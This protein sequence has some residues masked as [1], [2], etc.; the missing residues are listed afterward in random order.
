MTNT[1]IITITNKNT[2]LYKKIIQYHL[3]VDDWL[4]DQEDDEEPDADC[5]LPR[6]DG[7]DEDEDGVYVELVRM[8]L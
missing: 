5:K 4:F 3:E 8:S 1:D 7:E 2:N 6:G